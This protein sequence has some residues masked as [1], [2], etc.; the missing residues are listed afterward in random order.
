[1]AGWTV[2]EITIMANLISY[3]G[4]LPDA[5]MVFWA[6]AWT[7]SGMLAIFIWFWNM[8]GR[9]VIRISDSELIRSRE[10]VW[11]ARS[12]KFQTALI[13]NVRL[14]ENSPLTLETGGGMEFWGLSGGMISFDYGPAIQ[15][16]GLGISES[17][18]AHILEAIKA[19]CEIPGHRVN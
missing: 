3:Q 11:F 18:A 17:E 6:C 8:K 13:N 9:E 7:L 1:M 14:T 2:G 15:K 19:R 10:Y 12:N 16:F 5:F 4:K